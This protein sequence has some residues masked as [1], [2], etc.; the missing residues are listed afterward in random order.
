MSDRE[1]EDLIKANRELKD[2]VRIL[3]DVLQDIFEAMQTGGL[4]VALRGV[5][6]ALARCAPRGGT[7]SG[8]PAW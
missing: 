6:P 4:E 2:H 5:Q 3:T 1:Q 7:L 8:V